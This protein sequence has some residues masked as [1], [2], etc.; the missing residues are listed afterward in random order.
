MIAGHGKDGGSIRC[1]FGTLWSPQSFAYP[2]NNC[3]V[4]QKAQWFCVA[5][6][7]RR[8]ID[9][10]ERARGGAEIVAAVEKGADLPW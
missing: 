3:R 10:A 4:S 7:G 9:G 5:E 1:D 2:G 8:Y 6:V